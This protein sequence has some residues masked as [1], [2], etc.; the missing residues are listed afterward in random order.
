V[1]QRLGLVSSDIPGYAWA[2]LIYPDDVPRRSA[3]G[4]IP[5]RWERY[6]ASLILKDG[7]PLGHR[8]PKPSG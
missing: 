5:R 1:A 8:A 2:K 4:N 7:Q 3:A 6:E